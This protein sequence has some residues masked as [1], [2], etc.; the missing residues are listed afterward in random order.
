MEEQSRT[1]AEEDAFFEELAQSPDY[2]RNVRYER[3][4]KLQSLGSVDERSAPAFA[5]WRR[6]C[7]PEPGE[8]QMEDIFDAGGNRETGRTGN[9]SSLETVP[10][11]MEDGNVAPSCD[12]PGERVS[13]Q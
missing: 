9:R 5:V 10:S 4:L 11:L 8:T 7:A 2:L 1:K 6:T 3:W 12:E 13:S